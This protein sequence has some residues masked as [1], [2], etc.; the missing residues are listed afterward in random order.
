MTWKTE[1]M[2]QDHSRLRLDRITNHSR[3]PATRNHLSHDDYQVPHLLAAGKYKLSRI[4]IMA[5]IGWQVSNL[6]EDS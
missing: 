2:T 6:I 3:K 5:F 1:E 4:S